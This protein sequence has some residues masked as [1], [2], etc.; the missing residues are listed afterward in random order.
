MSDLGNQGF[1]TTTVSVPPVMV[2]AVFPAE[3]LDHQALT[4][5]AAVTRAWSIKSADGLVV[6]PGTTGSPT[7]APVTVTVTAAVEEFF[8]TAAGLQDVAPTSI[9]FPGPVGPVTV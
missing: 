5:L 4:V 7:A 8:A 1:K 9:V 2:R 3:M 6:N